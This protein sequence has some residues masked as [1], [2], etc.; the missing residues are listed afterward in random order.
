MPARVALDSLS[1]VCLRA[2]DAFRY[3]HELLALS[4]QLGARDSNGLLLH[5]ES[6]GNLDSVAETPVSAA[7]VLHHLSPET[8]G[9]RRR[10][11]VRKLR[12]S[13]SVEGYQDLRGLEV[14]D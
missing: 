3:R 6:V 12:G 2:D 7:V 1:E 9:D 4:D 8:G 5:A 14:L 13:R 11:R 10:L